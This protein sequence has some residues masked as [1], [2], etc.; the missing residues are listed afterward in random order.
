MNYLTAAEIETLNQAVPNKTGEGVINPGALGSAATGPGQTYGGHELNRLFGEKAAA[1]VLPIA[2]NHPFQDG[3]KRT[4]YATLVRFL[5]L[6]Q[7]QIITGREDFVRDL[8]GQCAANP[9]IA[10][11]NLAARLQMSFIRVGATFL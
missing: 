2:Q 8:I 4:A 10:K 1:L 6:N 11:H 9:P 7:Y 5:A 3:N